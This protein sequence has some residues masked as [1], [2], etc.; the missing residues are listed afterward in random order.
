MHR[1]DTRLYTSATYAEYTSVS[2][3]MA[4]NTSLFGTPCSSSAGI[5]NP[6][7]KITRMV[8][9]PRKKIE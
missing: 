9:T 6:R 7:M 5:P 4:Q 8:G 2:A 1:L 3:T